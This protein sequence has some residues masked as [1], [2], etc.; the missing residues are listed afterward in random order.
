MTIDIGTLLKK[1]FTPLAANRLAAVSWQGEYLGEFWMW[2]G[3]L[4]KDGLGQSVQ[5]VK[6]SDLREAAIRCWRDRWVPLKWDCAL[7]RRMEASLRAHR[8]LKAQGV[9]FPEGAFLP[10]PV[11]IPEEYL[12]EE[13]RRLMPEGGGR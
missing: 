10:D 8:G 9:Q 3:Q 1:G 5:T 4:N 6:V 13:L 7:L 2:N 11:A 12:N